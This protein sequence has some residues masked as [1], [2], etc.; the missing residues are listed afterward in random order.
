MDFVLVAKAVAGLGGLGLVIAAILVIASMKLAVKAD[1]REAA[2]RAA[3]PGANCGACGFPGCDGYAAAVAAGKAAVNA[4]TVGGPAVAARIGEIMGQ[5]AVAA[6]PMVA[7]LVCRGGRA[8]APRRFRYEGTYNC[9]QAALLLGGPKACIYG[10]IGMGHCVSVCPFSAIRIGENG[11]P[12]VDEKRCTGCG[13]CVRECPKQ[14]LA[15]LPRSKLVFLACASHDRGRRVKE[16]CRVGCIACGVCVKSCPVGALTLVDNLPVMDFT[17]CIDCGICVHKCPTKSFVD[18]APGRPKATINPNCNGCQACINVCQFKA[19]EG[20]AGKQHRVIAERCIGCGECR[21]V[22][23]VSAIDLVGAL[24]H[25]RR[26][27]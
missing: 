19:I 24:G 7:V 6:E 25:S 1:E 18:R 4:C 27:A 17:K 15:L 8:E 14:T 23:P 11:L 12:V 5:E 22:C 26:A 21:K 2:V 9:R 10:C 13:R 16:V 3:L 20:E